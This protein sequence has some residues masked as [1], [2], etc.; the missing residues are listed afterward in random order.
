M[1]CESID[2]IKVESKKALMALPEKD[3]HVSRIG[4]YVGI[5]V[6]HREGIT[7]KGIK[8]IYKNK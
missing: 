2:E 4:N 7:L 1:R 8:L 3:W 6:F 5:S